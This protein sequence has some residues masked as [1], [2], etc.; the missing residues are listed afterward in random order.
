MTGYMYSTYA[1]MLGENS[2][3]PV[4]SA[5][6]IMSV[7]D[8]CYIVGYTKQSNRSRERD[9]KGRVNVKTFRCYRQGQLLR[10]QCPRGMA[11]ASVEESKQRFWSFRVFVYNYS[12]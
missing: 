2:V 5:N 12:I 11:D 10:R 9:R 8:F 3:K 1:Y 7:E 6:Y 4:R